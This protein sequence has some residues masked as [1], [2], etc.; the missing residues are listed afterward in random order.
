KKVIIG[1]SDGKIDTTN[2]DLKGKIAKFVSKNEYNS[3]HKCD[4]GTNVAAIALASM[5]NAYGRPG[6]CSECTGLSARY[7]SFS[8]IEDLVDAGAKVINASWVKCSQGTLAE[9]INQR[10][11]EYYDDGIIIVAAAGNGT[12]CN[13]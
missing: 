10:I 8:F 2:M 11:N 6:I 3:T 12:D 1:I 7:G 5:D 4:H 9:K 13:R